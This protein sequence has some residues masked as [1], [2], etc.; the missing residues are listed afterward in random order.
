MIE[1]LDSGVLATVQDEGRIGFSAW[2]V[3]PSGAAD[4]PAYRLANRLVGNVPGCAAVEVVLGSIRLR[5]HVDTVIAVSGAPAPITVGERSFATGQAIPVAGGEVIT[6][7]W[8]PA[9]LRTYLAVRG[10]IAVPPVLGSRSTDTISGLG[11]DALAAG[12]LLPIG[13]DVQG[14]PAPDQVPLHPIDVAPVIDLVPGPRLDWID[15]NSKSVLVSR[16]FSVSDKVDRIGVRLSG[17]RL[18]RSR[19][20]E[21]PSEAII[22]GAIQLPPDGEPIVFGPDHPTTGGYPVVAVV[23]E[24]HAHLVAQLRPGYTVRFRWSR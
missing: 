5:A 15:E 17:P 11:P 4:G 23:A 8:A 7:G 9:G 18:V 22:R 19:T 3:S 6:V 14:L 1:V 24:R 21:L 12:D 10:G 2:A 13:N 20:G 16:S